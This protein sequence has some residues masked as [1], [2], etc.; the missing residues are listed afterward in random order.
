ME[1]RLVSAV[2]IVLA[3]FVA[4]AGMVL[5]HIRTEVLTADRFADRVADSARAESVRGLL[6]NVI[7]TDVIERAQPDAIVARPVIEGIVASVV[8]SSAMRPLLRAAA[9]EAYESLVAGE[10]QEVV[11]GLSDAAVLAIATLRRVDPEIAKA[12]P[13]DAEQAAVDLGRQEAPIGILKH[14]ESL[15]LAGLLIPASAVGLLVG[16]V[17]LAPSR[18]RAVGR[19]GLA[20]AGAGAL[21]AIVL[22][23]GR[24]FVV[25]R[26]PER[27]RDGSG[28][29]WD[30][31]VAGLSTWALAAV[32]AGLAVW[33]AA[34]G[35]LEAD[36]IVDAA[37]ATLN[38]ATRAPGGAREAALRGGLL[39]GTGVLVALTWPTLIRIAALSLAA[40]IVIQGVELLLHALT[41]APRAGG[42]SAE[43]M[44]DRVR[45]VRA[46]SMAAG[47]V[48]AVIAAGG[49]AFLATRGAPAHGPDR[50]TECNGS[51]EL[52]DRPV[53]EVV[54]AATHNSMS[55]AEEPGWLLAEQTGGIAAQLDFG[56][57]GLLIDTWYGVE[58]SRGVST[59]FYRSG[60]DRRAL[61]AEY[62]EDTVSA[63]E[64]LRGRLGF[65]Q[66]DI[67]AGV[68]LC[69]IAC[70]IGATPL[71][72]GLR[73]IR[74]FLDREPG[75]VL[76][77]VLQDQI[78]PQD[79]RRAFLRSGLREHVATVRPGNPWPT[80]GEMINAGERVLVLSENATDPEIPWILPAFEVTEETPYDVRS[81]AGLDCRPNRGGTG[82]PFLLLNHWIAAAI[83][84]VKDATRINRRQVLLERARL[85]E[86]ERGQRPNLLAVNFYEQGDLLEVVDELNRSTASD[87]QATD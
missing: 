83:P 42:V 33:L 59:D 2:L 55:A 82:R 66:R 84:S 17:L 71:D 80:L 9:R 48:A 85:C 22:P 41:P 76:I 40:L 77:L 10:G 70:E 68:Y 34:R 62:G 8:G 47:V 44:R 28:A 86:G 53:N 6:A 49:G 1:R 61:V 21:V 14:A 39:I 81:A 29:V 72:D 18:R 11:L 46:P 37:R 45:R 51:A 35:R 73:A 79:T 78:S 63:V 69:H 74:A 32:G 67:D 30:A 57:R 4:A 19:A 20:V 31:F 58:G 50:V 56:I 87:P 25:A 64:R 52:C 7:T 12:I 43:A 13:E 60:V 16:G 24:R 65:A 15:R 75:E 3:L 5:L 38:R 26:T 23:L 54:F 27:V 36:A